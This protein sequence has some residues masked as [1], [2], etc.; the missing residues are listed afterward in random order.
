MHETK[1][2][3]P[4][5]ST[6]PFADGATPDMSVLRKKAKALG[7]NSFG[8]TKEALVQA[9]AAE[10]ATQARTQALEGQQITAEE[11]NANVP[12]SDETSAPSDAGP[13]EDDMGEALGPKN[14]KRVP[15]GS[16]A[17]RLDTTQRPGYVRRW[18]NDSYGRIERAKKGGYNHV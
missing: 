17:P 12:L 3:G 11:Q 4:Q 14:V 7:I 15:L 18:V 2:A 5:Q 10:E 16:A 8:M 1:Q 9:I 13:R 6:S